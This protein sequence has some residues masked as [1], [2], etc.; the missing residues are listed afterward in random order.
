MA[1]NDQDKCWKLEVLRTA[2]A[3]S[4]ADIAHTQGIEP[5][6]RYANDDSCRTPTTN[7]PQVFEG[8]S[9]IDVKKVRRVLPKLAYK[10]LIPRRQKW[11]LRVTI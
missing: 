7:A 5:W 3:R 4:G 2:S 11:S 10:I 1:Q 6:S 8:T 9:G